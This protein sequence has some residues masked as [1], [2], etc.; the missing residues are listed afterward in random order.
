V[1]V[2]AEHPLAQRRGPIAVDNKPM[3]F[4]RSERVM[5]WDVVDTGFKIVLAPE[6]PQIARERVPR[7]VDALLARNGLAREQIDHW[8]VHPGG[9]AVMEGMREGLG[10]GPEQLE[11]TKR[12]LAE[13]GNLSSASVLFLLDEVM[14]K[15]RPAPGSTG[16]MIAMGPAFCAEATLLRW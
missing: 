13:V 12:C 3:F 15:E 5:G 4:A 1:L 6:V 10:L 7:L 9:P 16:L 11:R 14:Q 2:G 8:V